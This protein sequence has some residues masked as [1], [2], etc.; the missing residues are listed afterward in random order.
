[1]LV[2]AF[3]DPYKFFDKSPV[4]TLYHSLVFCVFDTPVVRDASDVFR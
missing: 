4:L 1:M 3:V 2:L